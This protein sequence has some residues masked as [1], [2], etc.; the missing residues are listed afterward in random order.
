MAKKH[1]K[2]GVFC[3]QIVGHIRKAPS[4]AEV[5]ATLPKRVQTYWSSI[6][7]RDE[8]TFIWLLVNLCLHLHI[9]N[10]LNQIL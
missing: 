3:N 4:V 1:I 2:F 7:Y 5:I 9:I 8:F 10:D 6:R